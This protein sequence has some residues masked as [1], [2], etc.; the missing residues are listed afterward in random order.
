MVKPSKRQQPAKA[1]EVEFS[2]D[3]WLV[4]LCARMEEAMSKALAAPK[5]QAEPQS[6]WRDLQGYGGTG[7]TAPWFDERRYEAAIE[8]S[9]DSKW[10][11]VWAFAQEEI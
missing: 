9:F 10:G 11:F 2:F 7:E 3:P 4:D 6:E 5:R 1:Q 8:E